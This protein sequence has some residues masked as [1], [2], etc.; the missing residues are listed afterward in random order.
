MAG[1]VCLLPA[2]FVLA[3]SLREISP[4]ET[5]LANAVRG[6]AGKFALS[7]L[8]FALVFAF[9]KPINPVAFFATFVGL[10]LCPLILFWFGAGR[11]LNRR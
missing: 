1:V 6:E 5:G 8:L 2:G 4:G 10:Q 3:M 7:I 11:K 9:V